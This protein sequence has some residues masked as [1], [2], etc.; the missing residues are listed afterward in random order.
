MSDGAQDAGVVD[1]MA[2]TALVDREGPGVLAYLVRRA[3]AEAEDLLGRVWVEAYASRYSFDPARGTARSWLFGVA[4]H[5]LLRHWRDRR[6][7]PG[8]PMLT[9]MAVDPWDEV[10]ARLDS[11]ALA[12]PLR[13]AL[14]D[15]PEVDREMLL[16]IA[17]EQLTPTEAAAVVGIPPATARTRLHRARSRMRIAL[18]GHH[19]PDAGDEPDPA[20]P[21]ASL[22]ARPMSGGLR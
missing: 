6:P 9:P 12:G 2:F 5:V 21:E 20:R 15:L 10:D 3:P 1:P 4:R 13:A 18:E 8:N 19:P 16:L 7:E 14:G 17:W 22:F 11:A